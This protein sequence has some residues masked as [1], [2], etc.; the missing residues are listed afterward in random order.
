[1]FREEPVEEL[2]PTE[3]DASN[4]QHRLLWQL[5]NHSPI[6]DAYRAAGYRT[7][8]IVSGATGLDWRS[9]DVVAES[10]WPSTF[11]RYLLNK[12]ILG[13]LI[14]FDAMY[15]GSILDTF[16]NLERAAGTTPRFVF[17]HVMSPHGPYVFQADGSPA[18]PCAEPCD[19]YGGPPNDVLDARLAGQITYLNKLVMHAVDQIVAVDPRGIIVLFS[20]HGV[21]RDPAHTEEWT[22]TM[23]AARNASFRD[24]IVVTDLIRD[25]ASAEFTGAP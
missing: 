2:L 20:D 25:L 24:D 9:A 8:S 10:P 22:R 21:R 11:E 17:A 6:Q 12:G 7:Y 3:W 18:E 19:L 14:P 16:K 13:A 4:S 1:M 23:F 15:R 5:I